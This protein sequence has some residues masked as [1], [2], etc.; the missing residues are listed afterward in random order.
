MSKNNNNKQEVYD[1]HLEDFIIQIDLRVKVNEGKELDRYLYHLILAR[2]IDLVIVKKEKKRPWRIL[3]FAVSADLRVK[4]KESKKRDKYLAS[5]LKIL[6]NTKMT[7]IPIV[8]GALGKSPKDLLVK[9]LGN[10]MSSKDHPDYSIIKI[11]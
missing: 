11:G 10:K 1:F 3:D 2:D 4:I 7:V 6:W 9:K 8:V 5:E